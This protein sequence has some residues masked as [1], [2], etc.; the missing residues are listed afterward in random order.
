MKIFHYSGYSHSDH[1]SI[2]VHPDFRV[3]VMCTNDGYPNRMASGGYSLPMPKKLVENFDQ[4]EF[5][6]WLK[7]NFWNGTP[8]EIWCPKEESEVRAFLSEAL[9]R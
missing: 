9:R 6:Q 5:I 7:Q 1:V 3:E 2:Y 8:I 4:E